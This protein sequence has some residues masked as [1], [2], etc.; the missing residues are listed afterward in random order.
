M[1]KYILSFLCVLCSLGVSAQFSGS[2][3]GTQNDPYLIFNENQLSQLNNFLNQSDVYFKL[4]KDIDLSAWIN[5]NNPSQGWVP[6][7]ISSTPFKGIFLGND[8]TISGLM[9]NRTSTDYVGFFGY[10]D[11]ATISNLTLKGSQII[12]KNYVGI[13]CGK[14]NRS[15]LTNNAATVDLTKGSGYTGGMIGYISNS[16]V[17]EQSYNGTVRASDAMSGGFAGYIISSS[18]TSC[19]CTTPMAGTQ[20]VGG[21]AGF[22]SGS[23]LKACSSTGTVTGSTQLGGAVGTIDGTCSLTDVEFSGTLSGTS[24]VGGIVGQLKSGSSTTFTGCY[25]KS[26]IVNTGDY[27][28]GIVGINNGPAIQNMTDCSHFGVINGKNYVGGLVGYTKGVFENPPI[29]YGSKSTTSNSKAWSSTKTTITESLA[30]HT[31]NNC[32]AIGNITGLDYVG[33]LVGK[34]EIPGVTYTYVSA[35]QNNSTGQMGNGNWHLLWRNDKCVYSDSYNYFSPKDQLNANLNHITNSYYSG[36]INGANYVGGIAGYKDGG[37]ITKCYSYATMVQGESHVGGI[38]GHIQGEN[39][40]GFANTVQT[41]CKLYV[42]S[43]VAV[44]TSVNAAKS[45]LGRIYGSKSDS[46][47][48][49][50]ALASAEGNRALTQTRVIK[51]GVVQNVEDNFQNGTSMGPSALKLK[52]NYVALGWDFDNDWTMQ[53]TECYP[54]K[55]YQA[56]PPVI[57]SDLVSQATAITGKSVNGGTVYL[58][59]YGHDAVSTESVNQQWS[60]ATEPLQS[61]A[62]VQLYSD[63]EGMTPSYFA[64]TSVGYPG[65]GTKDDP[66]RVYTAEDLQGV[67]NYGYYKMMNDIDLT[68][69]IAANSPTEGWIAIGR[70][71]G[72]ATYFD[73]D[74]HTVSG[75]WINTTDDYTGLFSNFSTGEICN[76]TVQIKEGLKVKGGNYTGGLIG[77]NA[78]GKIENV[79]VKGDV[80]GT[81][82]VGGVAGVITNNTLKN[83]NYEGTVRTSTA[84]AYIGGVIG[85]STSSS[86]QLTQCEATVTVSATSTG[87]GSFVGGIAGK[88]AGKMDKC[89]AQ[90]AINNAGASAQ[91]G[92]L[93]GQSGGAVTQCFSTGTVKATGNESNTGGLVGYATAAVTN[94]YSTVNTTGTQYTAGL[95]G[96][97]KSS[98]DKCYAKGDVYGV[99]YGAGLVGEL[100]GSNAKMTNSVAVNNIISL[101]AQSSWGSRVIGGYKNGA[102]DPE[103]TNYA[104]NT[105]QVSLNNVPQ[106]KTDDLVEGIAKTQTEL[107]TATTYTARG[108]DFS[109]TWGIDEG[110]IYPFLLWEV[111]VSKVE[112][113]TLNPTTLLIACGNTGTIAA[114]VAPL[115][116]TNRS[117]EWSSSNEGVA[118]VAGGVVTA[119]AIGTATITAAATDGSGVKAT[120]QVTVCKNEGDAITVLRSL[121]ENAQTL[122]D[123]SVE[124]TN[125]GEY[126]SGARQQL[127]TVINAVK[128]Q[129]SD[130]MDAAT[131]TSCT[132]TINAAVETFQSKKVTNSVDTDISSYDNILYAPTLEVTP[133]QQAMLSICLKNAIE[134]SSFEFSLILPEGVSIAWS[135]EDEDYAINLNPSRASLKRFTTTF[136]EQEDGSMH[137]ICYSGQNY[138]FVGNDGEVLNILLDVDAEMPDGEYAICINNQEMAT[139]S[140]MKYN[141]TQC[142]STMKV[143]AYVLGDVNGDHQVSVVD[144]NGVVNLILGTNTDGLVAKAADTNCD[145]GISVVDINGVVNIIL[146][147]NPMGRVAAP[148]LRGITLTPVDVRMSDVTLINGQTSRVSLT[149][150]GAVGKYS[151]MQFDVTLPEGVTLDG[152]SDKYH[153]V[154]TALQDDGSTRVICTSLSNHPFS[155]SS[156]LTLVLTAS[157]ANDGDYTMALKNIELASPDL[158]TAHSADFS[159]ALRIQGTTGIDML[160]AADSQIIYNLQGIKMNDDIKLGEKEFNIRNNKKVFNK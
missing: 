132:A 121:V 34:D 64:T 110:C 92:G 142:K 128:A 145:G 40:T 49:I 96:Y 136:A 16:T 140:M 148:A 50:G 134:F 14:A 89:H 70:N 24:E 133:G 143:L 131:I 21:F 108:W 141:V 159:T 129:I 13:L 120:C 18:L 86:D 45:D 63:V 130:T 80:E 112:S 146:Y 11:G 84:A 107:Q 25:S 124:G 32:C 98:I 9:I 119:K 97:T 157:E 118:T 135:E 41:D 53:E 100:D 160:N 87:T 7:G 62:V 83:V 43:N 66:Y 5:E 74:G 38:A 93:V 72:E 17:T 51:S 28:G 27:T 116:A 56:A 67:S 125:V 44:N 144:I 114:T 48:T 123:N 73:G 88:T 60:F 31:I 109:N 106:T 47:V 2:G 101:T 155:S 117:L 1:K 39:S 113:I 102:S 111:T 20:M 78:N 37:E 90:V 71:S 156:P 105:M 19:Q 85:Q 82:H 23:T 59:Y 35:G 8:H 55:R 94:C 79:T 81:Q 57:E 29:Y 103:E 95:V 68:A 104:L 151:S 3:T 76:L 158:T 26:D 52:A 46:Y 154:S 42:K 126:A 58:Y 22:M 147:G 127:L 4:M 152:E 54:Y 75:L 65:S 10:V 115:S 6:V 91:T 77:R 12:G 150:D 149:V 139:A 122:Y 153:L 61:G 137:V 138:A 30:I 33:G 99:N 36:K 15:T 69:W